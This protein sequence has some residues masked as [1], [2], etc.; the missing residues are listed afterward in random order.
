MGEPVRYHVGLDCGEGLWGPFAVTNSRL[1]AED[2]YEEALTRL[3][4]DGTATLSRRNPDGSWD[5]LARCRR[6]PCRSL[7]R[8]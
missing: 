6:H 8:P 4:D 3:R 2:A 5:L 1:D 7:M